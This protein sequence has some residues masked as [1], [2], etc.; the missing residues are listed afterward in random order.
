M[1]GALSHS[2]AR[3]N[4]ASH[5]SKEIMF[6]LSYCGP[7]ILPRIFLYRSAVA[8]SRILPISGAE[9]MSFVGAPAAKNGCP[10]WSA[11]SVRRCHGMN[12]CPVCCLRLLT[13]KPPL[14]RLMLIVAQFL[15]PLLSY[16]RVARQSESSIPICLCQNQ[17]GMNVFVFC[18]SI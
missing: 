11:T 17:L 14:F 7:V 18:S 3:P 12:R 6:G 16:H 1:A 5:L 4:S 15:G 13:E 2:A 10:F 9:W 8:R